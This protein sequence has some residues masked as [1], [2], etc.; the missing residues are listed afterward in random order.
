MKSPENTIKKILFIF[1]PFSIGYFLSYLYRS[2][3]AVLAPYLNQD[4]GI[5]AEQLGLITSVY[6]LTFA[7]FQLP[8]GILLD[9]YG[10]RKVQTILFIIA[11]IG[12]AT[13]ALGTNVTQ[14]TVGR[15]LI[16]LGVSGALMG[17][18]K[19]FSVWFPKERLSL[20]IAVYLGIG[21]MGAVVASTPLELALNI[22]SW[23]TIYLFL[24][25]ITLL[26]GLIIYLIVPEKKLN[27]QESKNDA[28]AKVLKEIYSSYAFWRICPIASIVGGTSMSLQGLW[29]GPWLTDVGQFNQMETAN[30]LFIFTICMAI[31][32]IMMGIISDYVRK[33]KIST[34]AVMGFFIFLLIIPLTIITFGIMPKAIWPWIMFSLTSFC[35]TLGYAGLSAHFPINY[36]G[37][38]STAVN[39]ITFLIAFIS[40]YA[41]GSIMQFLE[42]GKTSGYSLESYKISF[43]V[44]LTLIIICY[45]IFILMSFIEKK[46]LRIISNRLP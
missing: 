26:V 23:R 20:L 37:R 28:I 33:F 7:L 15:G 40:Q 4:L 32:I 29:A 16:G 42:P 31:G 10:A 8:L 27:N 25:G 43:G 38:V 45:V 11:S 9:K 14:L 6:F 17:A 2:T 19:A 36:A 34:I 3:N 30:I 41:I 12:A 21:A 46:R 13:F 1:I 18:F 22:T 44:F 24:S 39:L 5:N 35:G